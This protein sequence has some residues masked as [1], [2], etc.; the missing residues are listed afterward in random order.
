MFIF[1]YSYFDRLQ[2]YIYNIIILATLM[3]SPDDFDKFLLH[4]VNKINNE[5]KIDYK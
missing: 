4:V 5:L 3:L 2:Y 1:L